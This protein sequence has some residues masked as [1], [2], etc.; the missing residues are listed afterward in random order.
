MEEGEAEQEKV[1]VV[2]VVVVVVMP[3]I[4]HAKKSC[5]QN[6]WQLPKENRTNWKKK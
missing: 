5:C 2:E 6:I 1:V 3:Q 4:L